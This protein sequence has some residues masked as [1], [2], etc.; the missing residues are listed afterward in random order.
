MGFNT[1]N[2]KEKNQVK[3]AITALLNKLATL[4]ATDGASPS[5]TPELLYKNDN[6]KPSAEYDGMLGS[7]ILESFLGGAFNLAA[8]DN[9]GSANITGAQGTIGMIGPDE[10]AEFCSEYLQD[11]DSV[12]DKRGKGTYALGERAAG[13]RKTISTLFNSLPRRKAAPVT[14]AREAIE[15]SL[16]HFV[17]E[18]EALDQPAN[19]IGPAILAA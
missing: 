15:K 5:K 11:R 13:E 10:I 6:L 4:P 17:R 3:G 8:N 18:L 12:T 19:N 7:L 9:T 1:L 16:A 2:T 14:S